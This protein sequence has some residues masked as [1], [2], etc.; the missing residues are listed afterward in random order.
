MERPGEYRFSLRRWPEELNLPIDAPV[1]EEEAARIPYTRGA[2]CQTIRPVTAR[3][4]LFGREE[5]V[6]V[7]EGTPAVTILLSI[8][9]TGVTELE[10]WFIDASGEERGAYYVQVERL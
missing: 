7:N 5:R 3:L 2:D 4:K 9:Q 8:A 10:A 6:P 1:P